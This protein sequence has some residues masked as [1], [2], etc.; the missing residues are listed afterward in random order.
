MVVSDMDGTLL[1]DGAQQL[2]QRSVQVIR[3]LQERG[4]R[5]VAASGRQWYNV[6]NLCNG[7]HRPLSMIVENGAMTILDGQIATK[8]CF[9]RETAREIMT[10]MQELPTAELLFSGERSCYIC[11][12]TDWYFNLVVNVVRNRTTVI[13]TPF[14]IEDELIKISM[15]LPEGTE[16]S[17]RQWRERFGDKAH[18]VTSGN[19]WLDM[20]PKGVNK[21]VALQGILDYYDL[22]PEQCLVFGDNYNDIEM[23][24]LTPYSYAMKHGE[25]RAK[26]AAVYETAAVDETL[27]AWLD[28]WEQ[29]DGR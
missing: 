27:E 18:V 28:A 10:A 3:R 8:H 5:F 12:K 19:G 6:E 16:D 22:R 24:A 11:P 1:L 4:I 25:E 2:S 29:K 26:Q 9:D 15:W 20:V 17:F 21:G 14:E 7:L 23:L 13:R